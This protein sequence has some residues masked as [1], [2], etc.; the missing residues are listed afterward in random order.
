VKNALNKDPISNGCICIL[1][2]IIQ[3]SGRHTLKLIRKKKKRLY[4]NNAIW[5]NNGLLTNN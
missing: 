5:K 1:P 3:S 2:S 4:N